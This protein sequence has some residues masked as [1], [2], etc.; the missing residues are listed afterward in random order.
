AG[1]GGAGRRPGEA[2][3]ENAALAERRRE[4]AAAD[5]A[6]AIGGVVLDVRQLDR[7]TDRKRGRL[8]AAIGRR[9]DDGREGESAVVAIFGIG[10]HSEVGAGLSG[11]NGDARRGPRPRE[12]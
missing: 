12:R 6:V 10:P 8:G 7:R 2:F 3:E 5:S 4:G 9:G 11:G 1:A